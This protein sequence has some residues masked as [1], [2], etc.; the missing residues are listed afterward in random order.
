MTD[1]RKYSPYD[2]DYVWPKTLYDE[3]RDMASIAFMI[4]NFGY[5]INCAR[6]NKETF[7]GIDTSFTD[8]K[9][10]SITKSNVDDN[11]L[12]RSFTP[13]EVKKLVENNINLLQVG[14][15]KK[16]FT[17]KA[18]DGF[19]SALDKQD[20]R[21]RESGLERP[22]TLEEFDDLQQATECVYGISKDDINKRITV[23]FR[24]TN[25]LGKKDLETDVSIFQKEVPIPEVLRE[26]VKGKELQWHTGFYD[27]LF[28]KTA[29]ESDDD[30]KTKY[31]QILEDLKS[32]LAKYPGYKVY[33]KGHSLGAALSNITAFY[34]ALEPDL[35]KPI[36]NINFASPRVGGKDV[37]QAV[38]FLECS[39]KLRMIRV[40]NE[41]DLITAMP[42]TFYYH[43]G[44]Q[45]DLY[46]KH[47][48]NRKVPKPDFTYF[49]PNDSKWEKFKKS[50][51]NSVLS[52]I[53]LGY[54]HG[55]YISRIQKAE[56]YLQNT[57]LN[58]LYIE[59]NIF[60]DNA[61]A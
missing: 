26:A 36:S 60:E 33:V 21:A 11:N 19:Y 35:P 32:I 14:V 30:S 2:D 8:S 1:Q 50:R 41:N 27:Y 20:A 38:H 59:A 48:Y 42:A 39:K 57:S 45:V 9:R 15:G 23:V 17:G 10:K 13:S 7:K 46:K 52:K 37:F 61:A 31:D 49:N 58:D 25:D 3:M 4:Y 29:D 47:W 40:V 22:L 6:E 51:T 28:N 12:G 18:L 55:S 54:D 5:I 24:G 16:D 53:N 56:P 43:F 34:F 44:F